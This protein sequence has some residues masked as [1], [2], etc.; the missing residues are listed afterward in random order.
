MVTARLFPVL[1]AAMLFCSPLPLF[2]Q[3]QF[4]MKMYLGPMNELEVDATYHDPSDID[5]R[6]NGTRVIPI[7]LSVTNRSQQPVRLDYQDLHLDLGK[8]VSAVPLYP[9][10]AESARA[11]L[12]RDGRYNAFLRFLAAQG[13]DYSRDPF[14]SALPD[15]RL[16]SGGTKR[17]YVFF[18]RPEGVPFTGFLALGTV[19]YPPAMLRTKTFEIRSP[20]T[21]S[22]E[23][24][25]VAWLSRK[26]DEIV[27]GPPPF[28]KSY[29]LL[30]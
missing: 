18:L 19:S 6:L 15:G 29:A 27:K 12:R 22:N 1:A 13:N 16:S 5:E 14:A 4:S 3:G 21:E 8:A 20:K 17:G 10:D 26:W 28:R 25:S 24:W 30:L 11:M 7:W 23:L 9:V 2:G